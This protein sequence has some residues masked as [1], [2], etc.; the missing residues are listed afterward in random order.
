MGV[1]EVV[2][3]VGAWLWHKGDIVWEAVLVLGGS[4]GPEPGKGTVDRVIIQSVR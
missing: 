4:R 3:C 1:N 2:G